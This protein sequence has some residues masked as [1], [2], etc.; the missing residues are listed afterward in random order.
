[1]DIITV[2]ISVLFIVFILK[3]IGGLI[4]LLWPL[5]VLFGIYYCYK[6]YM[7]KK[8]TDSYYSQDEDVF[9]AQYH[10]KDED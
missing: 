5:I 7:Q 3:L 10:V 4:S 2:I 8:N 9:D 6:M 1:M